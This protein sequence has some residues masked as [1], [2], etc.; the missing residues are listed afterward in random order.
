MK[1]GA[2]G[3]PL[4]RPPETPRRM[5]ADFEI[6]VEWQFGGVGLPG[7]RL[8][9][10]PKPVLGSFDAQEDVPAVRRLPEF[11]RE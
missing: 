7:L 2:S 5:G 4:E 11:T 9:F 10:Q 3:A 6:N 1:C 8:L